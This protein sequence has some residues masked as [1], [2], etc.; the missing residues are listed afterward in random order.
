VRLNGFSLKASENVEYP[1]SR[2][3][4]RTDSDPRC[5][6]IF[7][8]GGRR[9]DHQFSPRLPSPGP[10]AS[11]PSA[12]GFFFRFHRSRIRRAVA[13]GPG[14]I[15]LLDGYRLSPSRAG[16]STDPRYSPLLRMMM[17]RQLRRLAAAALFLAIFIGSDLGTPIAVRCRRQPRRP[18]LAKI[19]LGSPAPAM[20]PGTVAKV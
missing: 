9:R 2:V 19:K 16:A 10:A 17:T 11:G 6:R 13:A 18:A 3:A 15:K 12:R 20:G 14:Q 7:L 4:K 5:G 8:L 1:C